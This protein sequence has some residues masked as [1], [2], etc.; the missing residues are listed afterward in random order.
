MFDFGLILNKY[1]EADMDILTIALLIISIIIN[2][3]LLI[4]SSKKE[5]ENHIISEMKI[6]LSQNNLHLIDQVSKKIAD[7]EQ[8][9]LRE[10]LTNKLETV[11]RLERNTNKMTEAFMN[12][13]GETAK[14]LNDNF[15]SLNEKVGSNLDKINMRVEERLNEGFEKTNKTFINVLER[16]SKID[17]AQKKIDSLS[18]NIVSLQ[19][20][21]TDK[22][23][24]G[25]FGEVQLN[26]ILASVFGESNSKIYELQK[27]LINGTI[28]DAV[29]NIPEPVGMLCVDSKFPLENYQRMIDKNVSEPERKIYEREFKTNVKKH[30]N[31]ISSKYIIDGVTSEQAI[32]FLPAEAIFAEINAYHQD[33]IDYAGSK[34]VWI[35][36][37]TT[38]MS[39][40]STVQVVIRNMEREKYAGI[41]H[42]E[43]N[44]LG[45][46]FKLYKDRWD[47]LAKDIK[48]V[49][50][51]VDKIHITSNK[52]EKKFDRISKVEM[53]DSDEQD[54]LDT[55]FAD[56]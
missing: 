24:R 22:K 38:L 44:K 51:D 47:S 4:K 52:I 17:E 19:D 49:S 23:S 8:K 9:Q 41:I 40:L 45:R 34:K 25:T 43:L 54:K 15:S 30:I 31:D 16:L 11:E 12:F 29:L 50:D 6:N 48:K 56:N 46:E 13:S 18:T 14:A 26:H 7:S 5:A 2:I 42:D 37:P 33:L 53:S 35:A 27:K 32:M 39:V 21:L 20:V 3:I 28:A 36:S 1:K 55:A 10:I